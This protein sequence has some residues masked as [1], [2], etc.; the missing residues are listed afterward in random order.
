MEIRPSA[1]ARS[2]LGRI[3]FRRAW[4]DAQPFLLVFAGRSSRR[5]AIGAAG[6][7][8]V[9]AVLGASSIWSRFR[10]KTLKKIGRKRCRRAGWPADRGH[11]V[12]GDKAGT[13]PFERRLL[14]GGER[15]YIKPASSPPSRGCCSEPRPEGSIPLNRRFRK[16]CADYPFQRLGG[17]SI[18]GITPRRQCQARSTFRFG[19]GPQHQAARFLCARSIDGRRAATWHRYPPIK[20]R[21]VEFPSAAC[22]DLAERGRFLSTA[23]GLIDTR[24]NDRRLAPGRARGPLH[25]GG[26]FAV[27]PGERRRGKRPARA[28]AKNRSTSVYVGAGRARRGGRFAF[29]KATHS[30]PASCP[31]SSMRLDAEGRRSRRADWY[32][33]LALDIP[34]GRGRATRRSEEGDGPSG[35]PT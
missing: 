2:A 31:E 23:A 13:T 35:A 22:A 10:T 9:G 33:L 19:E 32:S 8:T 18:A 12:S 28:P 29:M 7:S 15:T 16:R 3:F 17:R 11:P 4:R 21:T 6:L 27:T 30:G 5:C 14:R 25:G 26:R 20:T 34:Q 1:F 24:E